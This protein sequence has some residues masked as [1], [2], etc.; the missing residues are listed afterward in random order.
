MC[1]VDPELTKVR[2]ST[3]KSASKIK[4][5]KP[6]IKAFAVSS[7][8]FSMCQPSLRLATAM[9]RWVNQSSYPNASQDYGKILAL[10][11]ILGVLPGPE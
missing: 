5:K 9:P 4:K 11:L 1:E 7:V 3:A 8:V 10:L 2:I 6:T